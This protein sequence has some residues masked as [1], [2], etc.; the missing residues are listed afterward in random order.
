MKANE[1]RIGNYVWLVSKNKYYKI[2][3]GH[4]IDEGCESEDFKPIPLTEDILLKCGFTFC[5]MV[6]S[7]NG[8]EILNLKQSLEFFNHDYPIKLEYLHQLQNLYFALT[9]QELKINL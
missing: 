7:F 3:D 1:L 6:Y 8:F 9:N 2:Q 5:D 4:D